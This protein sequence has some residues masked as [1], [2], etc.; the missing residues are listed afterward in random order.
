[1][2][3]VDDALGRQ[4]AETTLALLPF[5]QALVQV[6]WQPRGVVKGCTTATHDLDIAIMSDSLL[7]RLHKY[8]AYLQVAYQV[9]GPSSVTYQMPYTGHWNLNRVES[10]RM[11]YAPY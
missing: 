4:H 11:P 8:A 6:R 10:N 7:R 5:D 9:D 1:M 3:V 2:L